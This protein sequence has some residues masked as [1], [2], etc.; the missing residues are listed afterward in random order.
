MSNENARAKQTQDCSDRFN[1]VTHPFLR[2]ITIIADEGFRTVSSVPEN[3]FVE[4]PVRRR[5]SLTSLFCL[6][7]TEPSS[8]KSG[9]EIKIIAREEQAGQQADPAE[10]D[11][12]LEGLVFRTR[13]GHAQMKLCVG[14]THLRTPNLL[15][16]IEKLFVKSVPSGDL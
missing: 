5:Q 10:D 15:N 7:A 16:S 4:I 14:S 2:L 8:Q 13:P 11:N 3:G 12:R 9:A 1:H 6:I